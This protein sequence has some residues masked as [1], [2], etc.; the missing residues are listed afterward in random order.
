MTNFSSITA[1]TSVAS[2]PS[3]TH[4]GSASRAPLSVARNAAMASWRLSRSVRWNWER[5]VETLSSWRSRS[6]RILVWRLYCTHVSCSACTAAVAAATSASTRSSFL[7]SACTKARYS[8]RRVCSCSITTNSGA[9]SPCENFAGSRSRARMVS[10][11]TAMA[12]GSAAAASPSLASRIDRE[13]R[14]R[15]W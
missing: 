14:P 3:V 7:R 4:I 5:N 15:N 9:K 11:M 6:A 8:S 12:T 2:A 13:N 1:P 10:A